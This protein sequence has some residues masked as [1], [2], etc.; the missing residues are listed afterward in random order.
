MRTIAFA[1][2]ASA[3][4]AFA[5]A[6]Q[7]AP[8]EAPKEGPGFREQMLRRQQEDTA[9][10]EELVARM[11]AAKG[12]AR[13]DAIA[14]VINEMLAQRRAMVAHMREM[15]GPREEGGAPPAPR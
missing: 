8:G 10:L 9:R 11:N 4:L 2:L 15:M 3:A 6:A 1:V 12:E 5:A 14:A 7:P 13:V